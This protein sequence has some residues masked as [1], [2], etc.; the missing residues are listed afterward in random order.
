MSDTNKP[1]FADFLPV[2]PEIA[3][4]KPGQLRREAVERSNLWAYSAAEFAALRG[5][6]EQLLQVGWHRDYGY[7]EPECD[8]P[9]G[10]E[11][12]CGLTEAR[13]RAR[14]VLEQVRNP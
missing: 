6:L 9:N 14:A 1:T 11:C 2:S 13:A 10:G 8:A 5:A 12:T 7:G 4:G 3:T